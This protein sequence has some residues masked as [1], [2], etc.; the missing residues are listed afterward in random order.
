MEPFKS[1]LVDIDATVPAHPAL[2]RAIRLARS[3]GARL[4]ITD[5][6]TVPAYARRYLPADIEEEMVSRRRQQ[7]ARIAQT[8]TD[9]QVEAKLLVGRPATVLIQE[10]LRSKHDLLMRSHARDAV[11]SSPTPFGAVDMELLRKCPC[12]VFLVRHGSGDQHPQIAAAVN[13]STEEA[14]ERALN[15][16][17]VEVALL[18]AE[19][20]GGVPMLLQA[21]APFAERIVRGHSSDDAFA[22]YVEDV[23]QRTAG[24]LRHL[25]QSFGGRLSGV[26]TVHRRGE[27][28]AVIPEFVVAQ[29]AD[30]VVMGTVARGGIAGLLIGNTAERVLRKLPCSVLAVKPD[31]FVCPVNL[32]A[33]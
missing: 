5:V 18:V 28:E 24:D 1:I 25:A 26:Q 2:A 12:P 10:V 4:T 17:I 31:G 7:L 9:I 6:M 11:A 20:E 8:V 16:K 23:R 3:S 30:L 22:A 33:V 19:L 21:W 13:A 32:D 15:V 27:P 14:S 29:G